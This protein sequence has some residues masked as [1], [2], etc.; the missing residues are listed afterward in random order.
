M[1]SSIVV[2]L[3]LKIKIKY[4]FWYFYCNSIFVTMVGVATLMLDPFGPRRRKM[5]HALCPEIGR[6]IQAQVETHPSCLGRNDKSELIAEFCGPNMSYLVLL[7]WFRYAVKWKIYRLFWY[8]KFTNL[9]KKKK[10]I[11]AKT[12]P[13]TWQLFK[14][15]SLDRGHCHLLYFF[16]LPPLLLNFFFQSFY[17]TKSTA[18]DALAFHTSV[19][20][21]QSH[22]L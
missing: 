12:S 8:S 5:C 11:C 7:L 14:L 3:P 9:M 10:K 17:W 2:W 15:P 16:L 6:S 21:K 19:L 1:L 18:K 22:D 20:Y 4:W 13:S